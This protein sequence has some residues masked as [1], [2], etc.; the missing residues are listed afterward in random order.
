MKP[1]T[2][3]RNFTPNSSGPLPPASASAGVALELTAEHGQTAGAAA[4]VK[5]DE[6]FDA[7]ALPAVSRTA[8]VI[9]AV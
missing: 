5:D 2:S 7:K 3:E 1:L 8:V 4:V 9:N 6:K